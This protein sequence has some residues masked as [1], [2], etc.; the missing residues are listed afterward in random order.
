MVQRIIYPDSIHS[1]KADLWWLRVVVYLPIG[2]MHGI[3][4]YLHEWL[5]FMVNVGSLFLEQFVRTSFPIPD[6]HL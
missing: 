3:F 2:S 5:I 4:T 6:A 1:A